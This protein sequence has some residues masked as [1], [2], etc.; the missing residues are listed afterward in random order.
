VQVH[1]AA[2]IAAANAERR[3]KR[4]PPKAE[5]DA[6]LK[7]YAEAGAAPGGGTYYVADDGTVTDIPVLAARLTEDGR[8]WCFWCIYCQH[9]HFHGEL[10]SDLPNFREAHCDR[11]TP[12]DRTGYILTP[13]TDWLDTLSDDEQRKLTSQWRDAFRK[14]QL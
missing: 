11:P 3:A 4:K 5:L 9:R 1:S 13:A 8:T 14:V 10:V 2:V 6:I 7:H 12:Y